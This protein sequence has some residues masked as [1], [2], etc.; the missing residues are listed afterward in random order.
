MIYVFT[1]LYLLLSGTYGNTPV[2]TPRTTPPIL[3]D[4]EKVKTR[5]M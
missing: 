3:D 5:L 4:T 1:N 2:L